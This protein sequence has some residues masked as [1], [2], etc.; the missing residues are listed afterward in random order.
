MPLLN[1]QAEGVLTIDGIDMNPSNG[2]W[3]IVGDER[4][5]GGLINLWTDYDVRGED[6]ILPSATGV[7]AYPRR[8]TA[9]RHDLRLLVVGDVIGQTSAPA[10]DSRVGLQTNLEYL[11]ANTFAPVVS[12]TGT[13]AASLTMF[14][15]G[16]RTAAIHV[17]RVTRQTYHIDEC[18]SIWIGTMHISIPGGR[19][20]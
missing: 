9:T 14:T 16:P 3:G 13:R 2:A 12:A 1:M 5:E 6:R 20:A 17:L 18:G 19:F 7:I 4:G 8:M 11:R 15:G 10:T